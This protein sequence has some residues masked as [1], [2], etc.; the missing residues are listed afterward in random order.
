MQRLFEHRAKRRV[1]CCVTRPLQASG[2]APGL[3]RACTAARAVAS[4][5]ACGA[6][7]A[8]ALRGRRACADKA[9]TEDCRLQ[10][11]P[12]VPA[13]RRAQARDGSCKRALCRRRLSSAAV[14]AHLAR[15]ST[16]ASWYPH[17][18]VACRAVTR[19]SF[20][21]VRL[22]SSRS[23]GGAP[24]FASLTRAGLC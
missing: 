8:L 16:S 2:R 4:A 19:P 24:S 14:S 10:G 11:A 7:H 12:S 22:R 9:W 15:A 21:V 18:P 20:G 5:L 1:F 3:V 17:C 23:A 6:G 13:S